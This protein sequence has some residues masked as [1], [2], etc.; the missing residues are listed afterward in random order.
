MTESAMPMGKLAKI[1]IKI[2]TAMQE[3]TK[4]YEAELA[5]LKDQ[6]SQV[7]N[8][9]KELMQSAGAKSVKTEFGTVMMGT[10]TRYWTQDWDE[11]KKFVVQHNAVDLLERRIAQ[12]NMAQFLSENPERIPPGLNAESEL[13]IS[14]R[15]AT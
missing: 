2:R 8:A 13:T 11:F 14:V 9:M 7:A 6:Q 15:K 4:Q 1:Y 12:S 5:A 3:K 10:K